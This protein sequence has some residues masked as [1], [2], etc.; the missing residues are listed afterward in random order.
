MEDKRNC[1]SGAAITVIALVITVLVTGCVNEPPNGT[2]LASNS[3]DSPIP[4]KSA[5]IG[6]PVPP[7]PSK[8][9]YIVVERGRSLNGIA[10]SHH[11][12]P[13]GLAAAN[14]LKPPYKLKIG[15]RL[16]I[17]SPGAPPVQQANASN[18]PPPT[19]LPPPASTPSAQQ[20]QRMAAS[21]PS[22]SDSATLGGVG[23]DGPLKEAAP[24]QRKQALAHAPAEADPV[25]PP[26]NP[27]AALP[28][29]DEA[30]FQPRLSP[31]VR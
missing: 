14:H 12:S 13:A 27:A 8:P 28:L 4:P 29:P 11:V 24:P 25:I 10:Y 18:T 31:L 16:L 1:R 19:A 26:R 30:D 20:E 21:P 6:I 2:S 9:N 15:S 5:A 7:L 22:D 17:P 23:I 3:S